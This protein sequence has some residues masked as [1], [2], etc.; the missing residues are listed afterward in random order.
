MI[1]CLTKQLV[2]LMN[3]VSESALRGHPPDTNLKSLKNFFTNH[4]PP[5]YHYYLH[6]D[7]LVLLKPRG[8]TAEMDTRFMDFLLDAPNKLTR[9]S[10]SCEWQNRS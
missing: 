10:V 9:V 7:D 6:K 4:D 5:I 8:D 3:Q 1:L 2:M